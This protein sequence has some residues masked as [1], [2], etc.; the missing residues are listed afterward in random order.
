MPK[1]E[2]RYRG[3][4][5]TGDVNGRGWCIETH[6]TRPDLPILRRAS[7]RVVDPSWTQAV[8]EARAR[9]D[10]VVDPHPHLDLTP[11]DPTITDT[12]D[13]M[14]AAFNSAWV[15]VKPPQLEPHSLKKSSCART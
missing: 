8:G 5:I 6:P 15:V 7:F 3:Y 14:G 2:A 4:M 1:R 13:L 11:E 10:A 12:R 9:I